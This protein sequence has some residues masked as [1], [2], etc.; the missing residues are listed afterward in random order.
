MKYLL[1]LVAALLS[2]VLFSQELRIEKN[3]F[4]SDDKIVGLADYVALMKPN[5]EAFELAKQA[6]SSYNTATVLGFVGGFMIGWPLGSALGG[7]DPNWALAGIGAGIVVIAIPIQASGAK[8]MKKAT[9]LYNKSF[10]TA[11]R[12]YF[13][14]QPN[15][16]GLLFRF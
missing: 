4:Y 9:D 11:S 16:V 10:T 15:Q 12:L 8:K 2:S 7:G 13:Q 6:K 3:R 14:A 1:S 5:L